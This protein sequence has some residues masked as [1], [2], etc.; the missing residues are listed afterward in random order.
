MPANGRWVLIRRLKGWICDIQNIKMEYYSISEYYSE[1]EYYSTS[2]Y[3]STSEY[4]S[5]SEYHIT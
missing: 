5:N 3:Y 4:Y 2:Q 1:S